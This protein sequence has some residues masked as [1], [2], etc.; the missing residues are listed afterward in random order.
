MLW[1]LAC[2]W[3]LVPS[4][5]TGST[6]LSHFL[7][8]SRSNKAPVQQFFFQLDLRA[9]SSCHSSSVLC[10]RNWL[11][12]KPTSQPASKKIRFSLCF[13]KEQTSAKQQ[14][15]PQWKTIPN[16]SSKRSSLLKWPSCCATELTTDASTSSPSSSAS[17]SWS[18][19]FWC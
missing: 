8:F 10:E 4:T 5:S 13:Q 11:K 16:W 2:A 15:Q 14:Q 1:E 9:H 18:P 3:N 17:S 7:S 12:W 19:S 6:V